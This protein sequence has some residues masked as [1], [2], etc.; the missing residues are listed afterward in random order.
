MTKPKALGYLRRDVSGISQ[1]WHEIQIRSLAARLGYNLA[2]TIAFGPRTDSPITRL[3]NAVWAADAAAVIVP[4]LWHFDSHLPVE[5]VKL[6]DV[7]TVHPETTYA[8]QV[9]PVT[10]DDSDDGEYMA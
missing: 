3:M 10:S 9:V 6:A 4:S 7:I 8:R 2:K 5:L 1:G